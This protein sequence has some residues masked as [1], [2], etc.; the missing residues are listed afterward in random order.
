MQCL[1]LKSSNCTSSTRSLVSEILMSNELT[2]SVYNHL[3]SV[4]LIKDPSKSSFFKQKKLLEA[5]ICTTVT[6]S[7][8]NKTREAIDSL[9]NCTDQ[10]KINEVNSILK[11]FK[12]DNAYQ[13]I[14]ELQQC[15]KSF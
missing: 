14:K 15:L 5:E 4:Y 3:E 8:L 1:F 10:L 11:R 2:R 7:P 9:F 6:N 13:T 12:L